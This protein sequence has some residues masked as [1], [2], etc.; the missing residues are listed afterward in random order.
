M[1]TRK[2]TA[3]ESA[4]ETFERKVLDDGAYRARLY[5]IV[6]LGTQKKKFQGKE[7]EVKQIRL[8]FELIG[9]TVEVNG[10]EKPYAISTTITDSTSE[11]AILMKYAKAISLKKLDND[12]DRKD[13]D[14]SSLLGKPCIVTIETK[15]KEDKSYT[16]V[17]GVASPMKGDTFGPL[18]NEEI[19]FDIPSRKA[20]LWEDELVKLHPKTRKK[21]YSSPEWK[22]VFTEKETEALEKKLNDI[23]EKE[24]GKSSDDN[25]DDTWA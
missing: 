15:Q 2:M 19:I 1:T 20:D 16:N 13:F 10:E 4:G 17:I 25:D 5:S 12:K 8:M 14:L 21:I 9:E 7:S 18:I 23:Y 11:K 24:F 22:A 6:R 3:S